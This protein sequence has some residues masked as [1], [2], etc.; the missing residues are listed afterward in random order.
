MAGKLIRVR[1]V[2]EKTGMSKTT[3]YRQIS[4]GGFPRPIQL[5]EKTTAWR[6]HEVDEWIESRE[7][8]PVFGT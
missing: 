3:M 4:L 7:A 6:E 8:T 1:A 2:L 5:T